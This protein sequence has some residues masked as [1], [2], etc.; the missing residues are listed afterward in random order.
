MEMRGIFPGNL[1]VFGMANTAR[2]YV[3]GEDSSKWHP[4]YAAGLVLTAFDHAGAIHLGV[5]DS[6]DSGFFVML[7]GS[8]AKLAFK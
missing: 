6:P 8:F 1:G 5:G 4:S 3:D 2:V 7:R